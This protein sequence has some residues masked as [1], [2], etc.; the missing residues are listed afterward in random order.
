MKIVATINNAGMAIS[1][2]GPVENVSEI[3]EI[4]KIPP[5]LKLFIY[6]KKDAKLENK[7]FYKSV[8]FSLLE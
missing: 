4:P 7:W 8:T 1:V 2:G 3:I 5:N 6:E